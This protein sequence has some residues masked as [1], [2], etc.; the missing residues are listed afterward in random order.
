MPRRTK[1]DNSGWPKHT[2]DPVEREQRIA[3]KMASKR[4]A[5]VILK[6]DKNIIPWNLVQKL[7]HTHD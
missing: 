4:F 6:S 5:D 3:E 2:K 7:K 1:E